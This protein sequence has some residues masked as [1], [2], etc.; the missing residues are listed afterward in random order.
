MSLHVFPTHFDQTCD[1]SPLP[2]KFQ[3]GQRPKVGVWMGREGPCWQAREKQVLP[4][5]G[6][7]ERK[8]ESGA[9]F[10]S[11]KIHNASPLTLGARCLM[12][13]IGKL[14]GVVLGPENG[15]WNWAS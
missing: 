8:W 12:R 14:W 11:H 5:A 7:L 4:L 2:S 9:C 15:E 1:L 13:K 3:V 6:I 10:K